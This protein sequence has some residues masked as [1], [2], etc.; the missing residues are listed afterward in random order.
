VITINPIK[1]KELENEKARQSRA[2]AFTAEYDPLAGK[3]ARGEATQAELI[4]KAEEIRARFP[5]Q[6]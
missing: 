3:Y 4:A 1:L 5:Y 6:E 2:A